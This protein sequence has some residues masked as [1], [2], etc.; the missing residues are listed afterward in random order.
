MADAYSITNNPLFQNS[1]HPFSELFTLLPKLE[2]EILGNEV[3]YRSDTN[4]LK[5]IHQHTNNATDLLLGS[6]QSLG[7]LLATAADNGSMG[8]TVPDICNIGWLFRAIGNLLS[9][10]YV[11]QADINAELIKRGISPIN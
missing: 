10:C 4:T 6:I 5:A 9:S 2:R 1:E 7:T 8:L 11:L 3:S